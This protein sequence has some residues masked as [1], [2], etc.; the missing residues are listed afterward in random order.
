[1]RQTVADYSAALQ[2]CPKTYAAWTRRPIMFGKF[3]FSRCD[4]SCTGM[5]IR[6][7]L[8]RHMFRNAFEDYSVPLLLYKSLVRPILVDTTKT[9]LSKV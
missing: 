4:D 1:M 2:G 9:K 8:D 3:I 6:L 5:E 7:L